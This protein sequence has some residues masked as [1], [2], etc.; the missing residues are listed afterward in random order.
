MSPGASFQRFQGRRVLSLEQTWQAWKTVE[1]AF[2]M[3]TMLKALTEDMQASL[4]RHDGMLVQ[5]HVL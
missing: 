2:R 3:N 1:N 5:Q 4:Q